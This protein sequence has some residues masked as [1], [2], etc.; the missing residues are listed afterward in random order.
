MC[1]NPASAA[2]LEAQPSSLLIPV[3]QVAVFTCTADCSL[4]CLG[5]WI[6]NDTYPHDD[7][8][9]LKLQGKGLSFPVVP[10]N[11]TKYTIRVV[12]N[13]SLSTNNTNI[14][15]EFHSPGNDDYILSSES[16]LLVIAGETQYLFLSIYRR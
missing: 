2:V 10:D 8:S 14:S 9:D 15:C 4:R 3:N 12:V 13:A 7:N 6:I 11:G 5:R 1:F 16:T